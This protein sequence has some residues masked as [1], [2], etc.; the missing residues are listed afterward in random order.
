MTIPLFEFVFQF[1]LGL[2]L[3]SF[4]N[5]N[6]EHDCDARI[7]ADLWWDFLAFYFGDA[8]LDLAP[9]P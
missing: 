5:H 3:A 1:L 6:V 4:D 2:N 9:Y 8:I 7:F